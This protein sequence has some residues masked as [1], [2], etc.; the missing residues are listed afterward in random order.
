MLVDL[1]HMAHR[2]L[3]HIWLLNWLLHLELAVGDDNLVLRHETLL[4]LLLSLEPVNAL[5][6]V[7]VDTQVKRHSFNR[8]DII[9]DGATFLVDSCW[10][11]RLTWSG[12]Q[13]L[14]LHLLH[15]SVLGVWSLF[16]EAGGFLHLVEV[17]LCHDIG[18]LCCD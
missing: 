10:C 15:E 16:E 2:L 13:S 18:I 1:L 5:H 8:S 9:E 11:L 4:E 7:S 6:S 17:F 3:D 12:D 14:D